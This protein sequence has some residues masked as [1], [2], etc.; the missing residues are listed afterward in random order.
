VTPVRTFHAVIIGLF[1]LAG[2]SLVG[3][4]ILVVAGRDVPDVLG[5]VVTATVTGAVGMLAPRPG[6]VG[7]PVPVEIVTDE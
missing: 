5:L 2:I 4:V 7:D 3:I 1:A 6:D